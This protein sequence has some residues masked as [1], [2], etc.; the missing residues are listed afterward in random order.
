M[1]RLSKST[2]TQAEKLA[3]MNVLDKEYLGM[4]EEVLQFEMALTKYFNRTAIC[5]SNGTSALQLACQAIG[6]ESGDE[7]L[8][9]S[10]TYVASFQA[11]SASGATPVPCDILE[12]TLTIDC[13][14]AESRITS[15]TKAIMPVHYGGGV[16]CIDEIYALAEKYNL[17]VIEDA[18]HAFGTI[19]K[20]KKIGSFGD[21]I[22]FS[23]D[24][25]KN[26]TSGEGGCVISDDQDVIKKIKDARLLGI[27]RDS[28][29]RYIGKRSWDFNVVEQGW[30]YHMSNI[31]AA[32]GIVQLKRFESL[33]SKRQNLSKAYNIIFNANDRII[34]IEIDLDNVVPHIYVVRIIDLK[35]RKMLQ[36]KMLE[37]GIETGY[38][39]QPNH[40][41]NFF[42]HDVS[43]PLKLTDKIFPEL[44]SL[45]LHPDLTRK[46]IEKVATTLIR[47]VKDDY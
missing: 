3:V 1:I 13:K 45:P 47:I 36:D 35:D 12:K 25:I 21:I 24:G 15:K 9:Q 31:M 33:S 42:G 19:Y 11:I 10:L 32:I 17:R 29:K 14:D 37:S 34:P 8:V 26:I 30:R 16:G 38:H 6:L 23:F 7:V 46:D 22:C 2:I 4:G 43:E 18:A 40:W 5:V 41:L 39:Y 27:Q 20:N 44:L 28:E